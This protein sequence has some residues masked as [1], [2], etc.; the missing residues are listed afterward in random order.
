MGCRCR[1]KLSNPKSR[2]TEGL[3]TIQYT[4]G[5]QGSR[6]FK[7]PTGSIYRFGIGANAI[8]LVNARD[9]NYFSTLTDF[10]IVEG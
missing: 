2:S 4:G 6:N 1:K 3:L 10:V 8:K 7:T 9:R 5:L